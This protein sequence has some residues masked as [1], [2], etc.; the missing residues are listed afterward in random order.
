MDSRRRALQQAAVAGPAAASLP[1]TARTAD[2]DATL[3]AALGEAQSPDGP[4]KASVSWCASKHT[5]ACFCTTAT[6]S[7]TRT[8][9]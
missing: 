8:W 3:T 5:P 2:V 7:S 9:G 4:G 1:S 6:T